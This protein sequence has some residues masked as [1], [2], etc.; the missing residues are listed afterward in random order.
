MQSYQPFKY[1]AADALDGGL[2][3]DT[4]SRAVCG[5]TYHERSTFVTRRD[6]PAR[7]AIALADQALHAN[8]C[9]RPLSDVTGLSAWRIA[10]I[11]FTIRSH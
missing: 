6:E 9:F 10:S 5:E 4:L 7:Q 8:A 11:P 2:Y 3:A 1:S